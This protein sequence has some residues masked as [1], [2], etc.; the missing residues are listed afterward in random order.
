M[1]FVLLLFLDHFRR[2]WRIV[3]GVTGTVRIVRIVRVL[4]HMCVLVGMDEVAVAM[5][6]SMR[7]YVLM[8]VRF[9][10]FVFFVFHFAD[11]LVSFGG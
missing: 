2:H 6:V 11:S 1:V 4:V 10:G 9:S 7:M 3:M 8:H 5:L